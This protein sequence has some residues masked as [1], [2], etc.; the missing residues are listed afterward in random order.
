MLDTVEERPESPTLSAQPVSH[1]KTCNINTECTSAL[2]TTPTIR[3]YHASLLNHRS[4]ALYSKETLPPPRHHLRR[5]R[6]TPR[7]PG[8]DCHGG[9]SPWSAAAATRSPTA[10]AAALRG[11]AKERTREA[12]SSGPESLRKRVEI[13]CFVACV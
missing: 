11:R 13:G 1:T 5:R 4:F 8:L 9:R 10:A 6:T 2:L 3:Y 12:P 7:R